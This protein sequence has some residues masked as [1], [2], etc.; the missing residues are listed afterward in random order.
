M[1]NLLPAPLKTGASGS[2]SSAWGAF[3]L[4]ELLVVIAIIA[5][6]AAILFPVFAR[7]RENARRT[8]CL[9]NLK[10]IGLAALQYNQDYDDYMPL[11]LMDSFFNDGTISSTWVD[12]TQPYIK[13][14]QVYRCPSDSDSSW[15]TPVSVYGATSTMPPLIKRFSSYQVNAYLINWGF[16]A[17]PY[18]HLSALQSPSKVVYLAEAGPR[19]VLDHFGPMCW[20]TPT[21]EALCGSASS[22]EW[23]DAKQEPTAMELRRHLDGSNYL[24]ADGHAKWQKFSSVW[25]RDLNAAPKIYAGAFDPRQ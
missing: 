20:G 5:I 23:D 7:A 10:Q 12:T 6:L 19:S 15:E 22:S 1:K 24:Y 9:S 18:S 25:F 11:T 4:I 8:S 17:M 13:S 14:N 3:T 16:S 2:R 21:D